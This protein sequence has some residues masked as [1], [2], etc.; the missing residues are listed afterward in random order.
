MSES[1]DKHLHISIQIHISTCIYSYRFTL[2]FIH[3]YKCIDTG[4]YGF[5]YNKPYFSFI[6]IQK[7]HTILHPDFERITYFT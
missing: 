3:M 4:L 1:E 7:T 5:F 2:D 6:I